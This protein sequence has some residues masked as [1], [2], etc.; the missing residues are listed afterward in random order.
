MQLRGGGSQEQRSIGA[1]FAPLQAMTNDG[2]SSW[3]CNSGFSGPWAS[4]WPCND[5]LGGPWTSSWLWNGGFGSSWTSSWPGFGGKAGRAGRKRR[6]GRQGQ[7]YFSAGQGT[8]GSLG[9]QVGPGTTVSGALGRQVGSAV[10]ETL[11]SQVGPGTAILRIFCCS[12]AIFGTFAKP[13]NP[14]KYRACRQ[15][16][17]FGASR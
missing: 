16:Q 9:R 14:L 5:D 11:G 7:G 13:A 12:L 8:Q 2:K 1:S 17:R 6:P 10:S 15:K 3:P 4:S